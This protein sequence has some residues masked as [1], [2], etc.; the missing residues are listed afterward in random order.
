MGI[1]DLL[2]VLTGAIYAVSTAGY[3]ANFQHRRPV[4]ARMGTWGLV[5][6]W[7]V[8]C[9]LLGGL[10]LATGK[11]PLNSQVLPSLCAW[12][13]V[14]VYF[15]LEVTTRDR[16]LGAL[17]VPIVTLLHVLTALNLFGM[18][19]APGVAFSGGWFKLHVLAYILA[20]A[21][22]AISCVSSLMYVMLLGEIQQKH[23][24]FFYDRL[25][26]LDTLDQ[27]NNRAATFGFVFLTAGAIASSVWAYQ[28]MYGLWVWGKPAFAPLL[29]SW[30]IYAGHVGLRFIAGWRGKRAALL[31]IVGFVLVVFAFPVVGVFFSGKHPLGQ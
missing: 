22:F 21:A 10:V 14:I 4:W 29:I 1:Q 13:V 18:E 24:G 31:S 7:L 16:S 27:M 20:Y 30:V 6:G 5:L 3:A 12:L 15:Y 28:E 23:L 9:L 8:H 11:V 19:E 2:V 26:P 25:P 17:V